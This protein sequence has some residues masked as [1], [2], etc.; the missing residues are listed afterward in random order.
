MGFQKRKFHSYK[1]PI[2]EK[3]PDIKVKKAPKCDVYSSAPCFSGECGLCANCCRTQD[4]SKLQEKER[5]YQDMSKIMGKNLIE[6]YRG[7]YNKRLNNWCK[8]L[9]NR[10]LCYYFF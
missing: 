9:S 3:K 5:R 2:Q 6:E 7:V 1:K 8:N 10:D 4:S